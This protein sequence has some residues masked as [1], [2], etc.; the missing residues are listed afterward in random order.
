[1]L[2]GHE[3]RQDGVGRLRGFV[4]D[5]V[6]YTYVVSNPAA[7]D[8]APIAPTTRAD[9]VTDDTC[10]PVEFVEWRS[11]KT[12]RF[13]PE[14][15]EPGPTSARRS[16]PSSPST[17]PRRRWKARWDRSLGK[18][19]AIVVPLPTGINIVKTPSDDLV[20]GGDRRHLHLRGHQHRPGTAGRRH[21]W[22]NRRLLLAG[23]V[24]RR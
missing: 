1:M 15:E 13:C 7:D 8:L 12:T 6:T 24:R 16:S 18:T 14:G 17:P 20:R 10:A 9:L 22:R 23:D 4:G 3:P 19:T 21:R 2:R 11:R 5:E